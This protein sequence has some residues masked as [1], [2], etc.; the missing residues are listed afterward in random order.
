MLRIGP[1]S[2]GGTGLPALRRAAGAVA[3]GAERLGTTEGSLSVMQ[4]EKVLT[5]LARIGTL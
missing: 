4:A 1:Q 5:L 2:V 3:T